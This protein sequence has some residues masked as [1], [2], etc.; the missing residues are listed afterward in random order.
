MATTQHKVGFM[1]GLQNT[2]DQMLA[3]TGGPEIELGTFYLTSDSHRLYIGAEDALDTS[4]KTLYPV[5]EGIIS[6]STMGSLPEPTTD[7]QK[8]SMVG[9][10]YYVEDQNILAV[11]NGQDYICINVSDT[12]GIIASAEFTGS[13]A[14][15]KASIT[16][17]SKDKNNKP[18]S[19]TFG[20]NAAGGLSV[21][22]DNTKKELTLTGDTYT[23]SSEGIS[24]NAQ[25]NGVKLVIQSANDSTKKSEIQVLGG[26]DVTVTQSNNVI[27]IDHQ[28]RYVDSAILENTATGIKLTLKDNFSD[29]RCSASWNPTIAYGPD[30]T[31]QLK[32]HF[33]NGQ[34][35]LNVYS[36]TEVDKLMQGLNAM[37]YKGTMKST[38]TGGASYSTGLLF[39]SSAS[40]V[41]GLTGEKLNSQV[42]DTIVLGEAMTFRFKDGTEKEFALGSMII[43][44]SS[45]GS[46]NGSGF[47]DASKLTF[48]I[49][50]ASNVTDTTY[51]IV[52]PTDNLANG[53]RVI[54]SYGT[55]I[56][57]LLLETDTTRQDED[58][59]VISGANIVFTTSYKEESGANGCYTATIK[60]AHEF[61]VRTDTKGEDVT[62][63]DV[64]TLEFNAVT[65][66]TT[67]DTGH[68]TGVQTTK[69]T[70]KDTVLKLEKFTYSSSTYKDSDDVAVGV[71]KGTLTA[72]D[73]NSTPQS[74][75]GAF[76]ITS[77]SLTIAA[78]NSHGE[79]QGGT[80][81]NG[82]SINM[83]W[84]NF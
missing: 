80:G 16:H 35:E 32:V 60:A 34:A 63:T 69:F 49:I 81:I 79:T 56:G 51:K 62:Q 10:F 57:G 25:D 7:A 12:T 78:D 76:A 65:G 44:R 67:D 19:A 28:D 38:N 42:G 84:G 59:N 40:Y 83:T 41:L 9:S 29:E 73:S 74:A 20:V 8:K 75:A 3:R 14:D 61:V 1:S 21:S 54:N 58:G 66:V 24:A 71:L 31:D 18:Y 27:T 77:E 37:T 45:D 4:K 64:S 39:E 2:V 50:A 55:S 33:V 70:V 52:K 53:I 11:F 5:N 23:I 22:W 36:K 72:K 26:H 6:V 17:T 43:C 13:S 82:I 30:G 15:N 48:D 47:I 68:I 46:E